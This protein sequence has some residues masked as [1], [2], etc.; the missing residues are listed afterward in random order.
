MRGLFKAFPPKS[1]LTLA[2]SLGERG[3]LLA[4]RKID[5]CQEYF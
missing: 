1:P 2:L 3:K 4:L 5:A